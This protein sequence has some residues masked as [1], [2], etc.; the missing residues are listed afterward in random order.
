M[1]DHYLL[2]GALTARSARARTEK[3]RLGYA[4]S[5]A[6]MCRKDWTGKHGKR[7]ERR[8]EREPEYRQKV[9]LL[10]EQ[11]RYKREEVWYRRNTRGRFY[12]FDRKCEM[13][14]FITLKK[15]TLM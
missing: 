6:E 1:G 11:E 12:S 4:A 13:F 9:L 14:R 7:E 8:R 10:G 3:N 2:P 15:L 5:K